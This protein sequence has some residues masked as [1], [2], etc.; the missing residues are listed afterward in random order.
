MPKTHADVREAARE[1]A[2]KEAASAQDYVDEMQLRDSF[3]RR[4]M[5]LVTTELEDQNFGALVQ[6]GISYDDKEHMISL[7]V[8]NERH[9]K[10]VVM[11][12][13]VEVEIK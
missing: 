5:R 1:E 8:Y 10:N 3:S 11:R 13:K 6:R 2:F 4:I 9:Y 12:I 7:R